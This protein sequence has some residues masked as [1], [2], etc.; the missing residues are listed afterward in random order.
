MV[1]GYTQRGG[2]PCA[3]DRVLCT[4][5]GAYAARLVEEKKF[6][7]TVALNGSKITHNNLS[8]VAGKTKLIAQDNEIVRAAKDIGI[9][10]GD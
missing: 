4:Q 7:V 3:Y 10:F 8:D 1:A 9:M 6:G 2:N 5:M